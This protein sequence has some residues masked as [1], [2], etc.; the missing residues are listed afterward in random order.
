MNR[1]RV[2]HAEPEAQFMIPYRNILGRC[3]VSESPN[4]LVVPRTT[5]TRQSIDALQSASS[6]T[7]TD[8][9]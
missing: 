3:V 2:G 1:W 4:H 5:S 9:H 7:A 6:L 8:T